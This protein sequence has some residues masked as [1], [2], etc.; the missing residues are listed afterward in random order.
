[1]RSKESALVSRL[2]Q[3][4]GTDIEEFVNGD[5]LSVEEVEKTV[6]TKQAQIDSK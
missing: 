3:L 5:E 6:T 2:K 1:M 4:G